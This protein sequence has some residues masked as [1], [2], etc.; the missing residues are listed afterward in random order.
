ME[1][2][3]RFLSKQINHKFWEWRTTDSRLLRRDGRA[4]E[5][6]IKVPI[7]YSV[8]RDYFFHVRLRPFLI[9]TSPLNKLYYFN[10]YIDKMQ[11]LRSRCLFLCRRGRS[12]HRIP[13]R[14]GRISLRKLLFRASHLDLMLTI[15][16][17]LNSRVLN[18]HFVI[19]FRLKTLIIVSQWLA[20]SSTWTNIFSPSIRCCLSFAPCAAIS[21]F[22]F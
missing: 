7:F 9:Q 13:G 17:I 6:V 5:V 18:N 8:S 12:L 2:P 3:I 11:R 19:T 14:A 15:D 1:S 10:I 21:F 22:L 20:E 4:K 16:E